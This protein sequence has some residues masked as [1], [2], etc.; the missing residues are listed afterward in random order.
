MANKYKAE[1]KKEV[2]T[3]NR[4]VRQCTHPQRE[5]RRKS[6]RLLAKSRSERNDKEQLKK[7]DDFLGKGVGAKKER[8]RLNARILN[9]S[10]R[11]GR[12]SKK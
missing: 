12:R 3:E 1:T 2:S 4:S 8:A 10:Q 6:A 9:D 5:L 7:L 11:K